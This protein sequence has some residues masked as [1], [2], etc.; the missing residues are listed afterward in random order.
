[1]YNSHP[2]VH[3][4]TYPGVNLA[5]Y[6]LD[7]Y[8]LSLDSNGPIANGKPVVYW[9]MHGLFEQKTGSYEVMLRDDLLKNPI[10]YWA[11]NHYIMVNK[12]L[13]N[14]LQNLGIPLYSGNAR[15]PHLCD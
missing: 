9:H 3:I 8:T 11:Y 2:E 13:S 14:R 4:L 6:N 1:M 5:E 7:N 15:Y 10:I 12:S